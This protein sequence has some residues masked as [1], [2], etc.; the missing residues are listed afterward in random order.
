MNFLPTRFF[1]VALS[2][3]PV[4]WPHAAFAENPVFELTAGTIPAVPAAVADRDILG[5]KL[6]M[7]PEA[8]IQVLTA[9]GYTHETRE[10]AV[11]AT[12]NGQTANSLPYTVRIVG[13]ISDGSAANIVVVFFTSPLNGNGAYSINRYVK[14]H[15][16][17]GPSTAEMLS[18]LSSKYNINYGRAKNYEDA[19]LAEGQNERPLGDT[20][21]SPDAYP[22]VR[23][24]LDSGRPNPLAYFFSAGVKE[25][26]SGRVS[27]LA[28]ALLN[29]QIYLKDKADL[30]N[31]ISSFEQGNVKQETT[32]KL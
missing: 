3:L 19:M 30:K 5:L 18:L 1:A 23:E 11:S 32:P 8:I 21:S 15:P 25:D 27:E 7:T 26:S 24:T 28:V 12:A 9:E 22:F 6:G 10:A 4:I 2:L 31:A 13:S 29:G 16:Q 20:I 14:Y 17:T